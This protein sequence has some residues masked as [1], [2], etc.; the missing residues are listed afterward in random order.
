[1]C[2]Y[3]CFKFMKYANGCN[4]AM[5][6]DEEKDSGCSGLRNIMV[7]RSERFCELADITRNVVGPL[8]SL[9]RVNVIYGLAK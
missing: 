3:S 7:I 1:M 6:I 9:A 5:E 8:N 4:V 2:I